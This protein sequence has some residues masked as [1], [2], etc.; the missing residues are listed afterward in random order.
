MLWTDESKFGL[1]ELTEG[2]LF[3]DEKGACVP[4]GRQLMCNIFVFQDDKDAINSSN[5]CRNY[6]KINKTLVTRAKGAYGISAVAS[7]S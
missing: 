3:G 1:L 5:Y 6:S 4:Y 7:G 2:C